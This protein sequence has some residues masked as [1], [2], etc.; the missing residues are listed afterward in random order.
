MTNLFSVFDPVSLFSLSLNWLSVIL[1]LI[2][3]PN[4]F[5]LINNQIRIVFSRIVKFVKIEFRAIIGNTTS[6]GNILLRLTLFI[7]IALNNFF[8]LSPY[9]FTASSHLTFTMSLAIP[10]WIGHIIYAWSLTTTHILAHLVPTGT[11]YVLMP[12]IVL[13]ELTRRVIRPL[14]LSVRLAANIVAGHLLL[15][16]LSSQAPNLRLL[17]I[18]PLLITLILLGTL[19]CAVALIQAYVFS[20]LS[21]LYLR[22]VDSAKLTI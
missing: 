2:I 9:T 18:I 3:L 17:I 13:I 15:T 14:T 11:P 16:L 21:T 1:I 19:E 22:E 8:G 12:F 6:P 7:F 20:V 5:W 10:I 4:L